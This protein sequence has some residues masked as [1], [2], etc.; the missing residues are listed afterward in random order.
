MRELHL[1]AAQQI[2]SMRN[3]LEQVLQRR[4][5]DLHGLH[6][7]EALL[8]LETT[9]PLLADQ[10]PYGVVK[11]TAMILTGSGHHSKGT[12]NKVPG[13]ALSLLILILKF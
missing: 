13:A 9:L 8:I 7:S 12:N 4:L 11:F 5:L 1:R 3:P 10:R 2:F 6:V